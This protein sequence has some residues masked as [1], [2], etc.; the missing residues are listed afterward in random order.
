MS[1]SET[2]RAKAREYAMKARSAKD[3][4]QWR[5]MTGMA[6]SFLLLE[7]NAKWL[8]STDTFLEALKSDRRWPGPV[9]PAAQDDRSHVAN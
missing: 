8:R 3:H 9:E 5:H 6:K 1:E 7:K 2:F 4:E